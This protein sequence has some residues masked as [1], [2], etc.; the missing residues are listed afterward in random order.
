MGSQQDLS[1]KKA[2]LRKLAFAA[3][4]KAHRQ[5]D[6]SACG[7]LTGLIKQL[8]PKGTV[9]GYMAIQTEIDPRPTMEKLHSEGHRICVP[10]IQGAAM[11]LLFREWS[12]GSEMIEG[13]FGALIP[14]AGEFIRPDAA[15]V[16]LVAFDTRGMRLGY[17]GGFYDRTLAQI[18]TTTTFH[19]IGFAYSAQ[20]IDEVPTDEFDQ[21]L[22]YIVTEV[23]TRCFS[24]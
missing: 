1:E 7:Y 10:V 24:G 22:D 21:R 11:P 13:D 19:A 23:G 15:I 3:R 2:A 12:P 9:A 20:E 5:P 17:G 16:P 18:R 6:P 4:K 8:A 14:R